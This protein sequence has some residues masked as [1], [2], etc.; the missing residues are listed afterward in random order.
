MFDARYSEKREHGTWKMAI[1]S[2]GK[3]YPIFWC[4]DCGR[5]MALRRHK[6]NDDGSVNPSVVCAHKCPKCD[7]NE[8]IRLIKEVE[9]C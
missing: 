2:K 7:F 5:A 4:P 1:N 9:L 8:H 3:R 6:I